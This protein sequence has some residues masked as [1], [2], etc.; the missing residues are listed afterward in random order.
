MWA[1]SL[2]VSFQAGPDA[3]IRVLLVVNLLVILLGGSAVIARKYRLDPSRHLFMNRPAPAQVLLAIPGAVA[4]IVFSLGVYKLVDH[5]LPAGGQLETFARTLAP[6]SLPDLQTLIFLCVL[7]AVCEETAFRGL[8]LGGLS[9][10]W[11]KLPAIA[12][13]A[14]FFAVFHVYWFRFVP[15]AVLG[16][17]LGLCTLY[18]RSLVPAMLWHAL[19]NSL[20]IFSPELLDPA[21]LDPAWYPVSAVVLFLV[22]LGMKKSAGSAAWRA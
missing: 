17:L 20:A 12:V 4:G 1:V 15:T 9:M 5:F 6:R 14:I 19:N 13:S 22:L 3:D 11:R 7:P 10:R 8:L 2:I 21:G 18:T 16:V